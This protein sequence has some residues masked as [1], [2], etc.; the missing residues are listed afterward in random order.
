MIAAHAFE[1]MERIIPIPPSILHDHDPSKP[2]HPTWRRTWMDG[3]GL[4][5]SSMCTY[6]HG[7]MALSK[8]AGNY[9]VIHDCDDKFR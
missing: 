7:S 9:V 8:I 5:R 4:F 1:C 2:D 3:D 6:P